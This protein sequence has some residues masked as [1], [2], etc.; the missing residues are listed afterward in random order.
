MKVGSHPY[1]IL[2]CKT[3]DGKPWKSLC[4]VDSAESV[5][6]ALVELGVSLCLMSVN[7]SYG[8]YFQDQ[9][10]TYLLSTLDDIEGAD[11][12]VGDTAG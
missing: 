1:G 5:S 10:L 7:A 3:Y 9:L 6:H 2:G 11:D 4:S 8:R 12:S